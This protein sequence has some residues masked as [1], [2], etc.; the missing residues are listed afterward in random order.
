LWTMIR[1]RGNS[2]AGQLKHPTADRPDA[3]I[4]QALRGLEHPV[5]A[6]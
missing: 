1:G 3:P 6:G 4:Y 5:V 2:G